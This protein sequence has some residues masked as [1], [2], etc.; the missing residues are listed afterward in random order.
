VWLLIL[1]AGYLLRRKSAP[2]P[3]A[4]LEER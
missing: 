2:A 3:V 4:A 1:A